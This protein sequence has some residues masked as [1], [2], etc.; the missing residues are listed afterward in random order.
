[1]N[2]QERSKG[3]CQL[4]ESYSDRSILTAPLAID[5]NTSNKT[6]TD[7]C[8]VQNTYSYNIMSG[9]EHN[10]PL[11]ILPWLALTVSVISIWY[12]WHNNKR[13][14][15]ISVEDDYWLRTVVFPSILTPLIEIGSKSPEYF[16][17]SDS[18]ADFFSG[19][20][21]Q[22]M[23][24]LRDKTMV[25]KLVDEELYINANRI[26][27]DLDDKVSE[28]QTTNDYCEVFGNFSSKLTALLKDAQSKT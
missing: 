18:L 23:N 25:L 16:R 9:N 3:A 2:V 15:T 5:L 6:D 1:M 19:Y 7:T 10:K 21:L 17:A 24:L 14:R 12:T 20:F 26:M 4:T 22:E 28:V 8:I 27:D 11:D 13:Q